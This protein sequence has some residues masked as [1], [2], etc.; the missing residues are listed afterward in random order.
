[1]I[2]GGRTGVNIARFSSKSESNS[3]PIFEQVRKQVRK[4]VTEG[5][6]GLRLCGLASLTDIWSK[7]E[8]KSPSR[9]HP[10]FEQV[11]KQ[12]I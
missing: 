6:N 2:L 3:H 11:R 8:S 12:L 5:R 10:V 4:Q 1:M 9:S 7:A